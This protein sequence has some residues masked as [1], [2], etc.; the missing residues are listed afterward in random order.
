MKDDHNNIH[1]IQHIYRVI[2]RHEAAASAGSFHAHEN[3][4][5][6]RRIEEDH[7]PAPA[8]RDDAKAIRK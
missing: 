4:G 1:A 2:A 3:A 6:L 8:M 7:C 5:S